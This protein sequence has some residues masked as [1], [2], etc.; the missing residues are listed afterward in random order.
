MDAKE[1]HD[2]AVSFSEKVHYMVRL[3]RPETWI[4]WFC[5]STPNPVTYEDFL[6][7]CILTERF[8]TSEKLMNVENAFIEAVESGMR[9]TQ[10]R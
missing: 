10:R 1:V 3:N 7:F 6:V 5:T 9:E 4:D 8:M 2:I